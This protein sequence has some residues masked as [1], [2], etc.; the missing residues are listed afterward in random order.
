MDEVVRYSYRL[1]PGRIA[2][3]A[4]FDEWHRCRFL[5]NEA[6]HQHK[7]G[8]KPTFGKLG[9]QLTETRKHS[10][11]LRNGSQEQQTLRTFARALDSSFRGE[12]RGRPRGKARK[13]TLPSLEYT[14]RGFGLRG[15]RSVLAKGISIQVVWS[16]ES[17]SEPTSVRTTQDSWG[18]RYAAFVVTREDNVRQ[19]DH[20]LRDGGAVAV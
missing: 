11:W 13:K 19:V 20:L 5:W 7:P 17:P 2:E 10:S 4:L 15:G 6:V 12:G 14:R 18:H 3:R 16:R 8:S 1:R 9:K